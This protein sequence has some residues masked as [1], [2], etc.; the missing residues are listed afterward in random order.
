MIVQL[1][2]IIQRQVKT[3][4]RFAPLNAVDYVLE[5][6]IVFAAH[7]PLQPPRPRRHGAGVMLIQALEK[8]VVVK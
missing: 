6:R 2:T 8:T 7:L 5:F 1:L 4:G 3:L